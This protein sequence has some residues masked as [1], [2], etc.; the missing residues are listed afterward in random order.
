MESLIFFWKLKLIAWPSV[1][2][3]G[4]LFPA[5]GL[6]VFNSKPMRKAGCGRAGLPG[7]GT[8]AGCLVANGHP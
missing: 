1:S 6:S 7:K 3:S 4:F 8:S 2:F 5:D